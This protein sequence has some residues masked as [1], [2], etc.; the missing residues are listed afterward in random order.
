MTGTTVLITVEGEDDALALQEWLDQD[1]DFRGR[2]RLHKQTA[3]EGTM[4]SALDTVSL[5]VTSGG[6]TAVTTALIAYLK[7]RGMTVKITAKVG[8]KTATIEGDRVR[9]K[10]L[11]ELNDTAAALAKQLGE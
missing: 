8:D 1:D 4:G 7:T 10:G 5:V 11:R 2:A 6:L 9:R 3:G